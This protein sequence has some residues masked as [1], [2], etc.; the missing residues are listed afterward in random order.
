M[1]YFVHGYCSIHGLSVQMFFNDLNIFLDVIFRE[2]LEGCLKND[3]ITIPSSADF[4]NLD[5]LQFFGL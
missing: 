2:M 4:Q 1:I 5:L 3:G